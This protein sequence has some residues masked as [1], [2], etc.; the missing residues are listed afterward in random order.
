MNK[1]VFNA[2]AESFTP[3]RPGEPFTFAVSD[4]GTIRKLNQLFSKHGSI[5]ITIQSAEKARQEEK[6]E[7]LLAALGT[8]RRRRR[9]FFETM[10]RMMD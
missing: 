3:P 6:A 10:G 9:G 8:H 5:R 7:L 4:E 2:E 1:V